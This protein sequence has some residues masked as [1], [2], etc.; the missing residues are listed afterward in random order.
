MQR[1]SILLLSCLTVGALAVA[2][3]QDDPADT[4]IFGRELEPD[5]QS[6]LARAM[7][8]AWQLLDIDD[9]DLPEDGRSANGFL[10]V[11]GAFASIELQL[12][13]ESF[14]DAYQ[15]GTYEIRVN[16]TG[17]MIM[18]TLLGSYLTEDGELLWEP[19]GLMRRFRVTVAGDLLSLV[20]DDGS[21]FDFI[22]RN[23]SRFFSSDFYDDYYDDEEDDDVEQEE[24][25]AIGDFYGRN[26]PADQRSEKKKKDER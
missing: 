9:I 23:K 3:R 18:S 10:L 24:F 8:G 4:D 22:R 6:K 11:S 26:Q 1:I 19:P 15:T 20:R 7:Q 25:D 5:S 21:R 17:D 16:A 2:A 14:E 13:W 12:Q